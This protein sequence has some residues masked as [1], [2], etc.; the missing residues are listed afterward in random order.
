MDK[1]GPSIA[2]CFGLGVLGGAVG[3]AG[4]GLLVALVFGQ[5]VWDALSRG[6]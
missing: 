6:G 5:R 4:L 3:I 2:A 1:S